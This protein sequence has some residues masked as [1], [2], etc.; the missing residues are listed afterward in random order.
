MPESAAMIERL[1]MLVQRTRDRES[2][3]ARKRRSEP[4]HRSK[5]RLEA[6]TGMIHDEAVVGATG[7]EPV[8]PPV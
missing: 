7:I 2:E 1:H 5:L 8:T 4:N 3:L 6:R